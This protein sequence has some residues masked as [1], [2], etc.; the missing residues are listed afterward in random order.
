MNVF[1]KAT[2][3]MDYSIMEQVFAQSKEISIHD[4]VTFLDNA[5]TTPESRFDALYNLSIF[6]EKIDRQALLD[7]QSELYERSIEMKDTARLVNTVSSY[8]FLLFLDGKYLQSLDTMQAVADY[9]T[10]P[11]DEV[12]GVARGEALFL[13][14]LCYSEL[15]DIETSIKLMMEYLSIAQE[16]YV[17]NPDMLPNAYHILSGIFNEKGMYDS[18]IFYNERGIESVDANSVRWAYLH[19]DLANSYRE[20][21]RYSEA[22]EALKLALP[23][24]NG[25]SENHGLMSAN[26][27]IALNKSYLGDSDS[28]YHYLDR[29]R[30]YANILDASLGQSALLNIEH[31]AFRN[32]EDFEKAYQSLLILNSLN[33]S[34]NNVEIKKTAKEMKEKYETT[35]KEA[36]NVALKAENDQQR[37]LIF[38]AVIFAVLFAGFGIYIY[39]TNQKTKALYAQISAQAFE[40]NKA[41]K[42]KD[43][44]FSII[45]H[46]LR[47]PIT[48][49]ET[50][51]GLIKNYLDKKDLDKVDTMVHHV[52]QSTKSLKMLLDNLLNWSLGQQG[53]I[54]INIEPM[55]VRLI[56]DELFEVL[57]DS[58]RLKNIHLVHQLTNE[59]ILADRD[60][61]TT[62]FRNLL[63]NAIKFSPPGAQITVAHKVE[64]N[65][66]EVTV[67]DEGIGMDQDQLTKLF[68]ID[69]SKVR[70]GTAKEK[71]TGL[72][73]VLVKEFVDMN[74]GKISVDSRPGKGSMFAIKLPLAS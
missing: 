5:N 19:V 63:S 24:L 33:D 62:V 53:E 58:T 67:Q 11:Y 13:Q 60:T 23:V 43:R 18:A 9:I 59:Q 15:G 1:L 49:F 72:G 7:L 36:E 42:T 34:L 45:G 66:I 47:G 65:F 38:I 40:L 46:D 31:K 57:A 48:S 71:G 39:R 17:T 16:L 25:G 44:L 68:E 22:V 52:D 56:I 26:A 69:K 4:W 32:I 50:A 41:N 51:N 70:K 37:L 6:Y 12:T 55:E 64:G 14:Y 28:V 2:V 35:Q 21:G 29:A 54:S 74:H 73:L 27:L 3:E 61:I 8:S 10:P 20:I 30:N